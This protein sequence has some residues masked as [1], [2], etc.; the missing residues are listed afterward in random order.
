MSNKRRYIDSWCL[1]S[2]NSCDVFWSTE[3]ALSCEW[4]TVPHPAWPAEDLQH[5]RAVVFPHIL[6]AVAEVTGSR[7][8]GVSA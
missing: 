7:V 1:P 8:L 6:A 5:W 2:G 3:G 4:D